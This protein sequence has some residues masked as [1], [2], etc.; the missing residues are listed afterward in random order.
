LVGNGRDVWH[1]TPAG[2]QEFGT[3]YAK[4]YLSLAS[5]AWEPR[6]GTTSIDKGKLLMGP[7]SA[8]ASATDAELKIISLDGRILDVI[9]PKHGKP[10]D[11]PKKEIRL[12]IDAP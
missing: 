6:Q 7:A 8:G 10:A 4:A 11:G 2:F 5:G 3:R 1:F 9:Q 12:N